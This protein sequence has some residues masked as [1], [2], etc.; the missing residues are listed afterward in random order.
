LTAS[1]RG[2]SRSIRFA[3]SSSLRRT[4]C[5]GTQNNVLHRQHPAGSRTT[6][7][8]WGS[9]G[10]T[11]HPWRRTSSCHVPNQLITRNPAAR[12]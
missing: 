5:A 10:S 2:R 1:I 4:P 9:L 8:A 3:V 11:R 6:L 7:R 12:G